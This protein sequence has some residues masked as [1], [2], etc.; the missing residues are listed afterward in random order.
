MTT[1]YQRRRNESIAGPVD[2]PAAIPYA[3]DTPDLSKEAKGW[4]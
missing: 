2:F 3:L 4:T 1:F